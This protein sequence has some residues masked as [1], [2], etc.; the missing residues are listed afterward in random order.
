MRASI[1]CRRSDAP[2]NAHQ[3]PVRFQIVCDKSTRTAH[4]FWL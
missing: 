2:P 3:T 4:F 1:G